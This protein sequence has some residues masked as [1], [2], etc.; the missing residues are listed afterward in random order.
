MSIFS[1]DSRTNWAQAFVSGIPYAAFSGMQVVDI[2]QGFVTLLLPARATWTGDTQRNLIHAGCLSVLADTA[3]GLAVGSA[4]EEMEPF[5]TLDL[6]MDYLRPPVANVNV[7]CRAECHRLSR[8][9]AFVRATAFDA[10]EGRPVAQA[11]GA[12]TVDRPVKA[13]GAA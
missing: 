4:M 6:R 8:S 13:G 12:F 3:C 7:T 11:V 9:V 1:S 5:A 2:G 10:D